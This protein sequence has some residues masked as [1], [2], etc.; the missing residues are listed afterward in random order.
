MGTSNSLFLKAFSYL[1]RF[2]LVFVFISCGLNVKNNIDDKKNVKTDYCKD[3][4][5]DYLSTDIKVIVKDEN[6]YYIGKSSFFEEFFV[7]NEVCFLKKDSSFLKTNF[8]EPT[9]IKWNPEL[10]YIYNFGEEKTGFYSY[11]IFYFNDN[12]RIKDLSWNE[13]FI[14]E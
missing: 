10:K 8:G 6:T 14:S 3:L 4:I 5:I 1:S 7:Y 13:T 2:V 9:I 12:G 11:L